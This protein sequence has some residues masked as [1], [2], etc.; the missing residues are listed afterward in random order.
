MTASLL[1]LVLVLVLVVVGAVGGLWVLRVRSLARERRRL[2]SLA[3]VAQRL[4]AARLD[5]PRT[6]DEEPMPS[7]PPPPAVPRGRAALVDAVTD[8]VAR[9]RADGERVA[10][11]V[12]ETPDSTAAALARDV[13]AIT[14]HEVY[15][16]GARS[17]ALV[18]PAAGR[19]ETLGLLA[20]IEAGCGAR[21]RA[22]ELEPGEDAVALLARGLGSV[23]EG[24]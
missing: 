8:A 7:A 1:L 5:V 3:G 18:V 16:V 19:A 11:A 10:L 21:G 22:V 9:A 14:G 2:A 15:T 12:I 23:T 4:E 13:G 17:V 6:R 20:R 24:D